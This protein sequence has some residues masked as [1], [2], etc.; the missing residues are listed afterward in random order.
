MIIG[1]TYKIKTVKNLALVTHIYKYYL[2]FFGELVCYDTKPGLSV[3]TSM[4]PPLLLLVRIKWIKNI[5]DFSSFKY[6]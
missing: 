4:I 3:P 5:L 1:K 2:L 6:K